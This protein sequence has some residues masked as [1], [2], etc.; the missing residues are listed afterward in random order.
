ME[1]VEL[2]PW[3]IPSLLLVTVGTLIGSYFSFKN[4]KYVMMMGIGMVQTFISTLLITS[5][6]SI[7]FGI[8]LTQFY[9]GIVNTKRVKAMSHE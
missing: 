5:V 1:L 6:G 8:G 2:Y 9:L 7:L 3:L 4:E